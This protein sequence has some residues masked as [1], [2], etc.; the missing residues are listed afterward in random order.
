MTQDEML[1][2]ELTLSHKLAFKIQEAAELISVSKRTMERLIHDRK[3]LPTKALHLITQEELLRYLRE[4]VTQTRNT[5][6]RAKR[7]TQ[8]TQPAT[9]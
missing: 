2:P 3:I 6:R 9:P 5:K 7:F 8:P 4:E 1:I